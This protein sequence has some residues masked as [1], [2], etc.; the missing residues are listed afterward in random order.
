MYKNWLINI[1]LVIASLTIFVGGME[2][3]LRVTGLQS[4]TPKPPPIY[5]RNTNPHINYELVPNTKQEAYYATVTTNS[6]GFRGTEIEKDKPLVAVLGDSI[7]FGYGVEDDETLPAQ[8]QKLMPN[9]H[10]LNTA[11]PGYDLEQETATYITKVKDLDPAAVMLVFF[12]NDLYAGGPAILDDE[13]ILRPNGWTPDKD[14]CTS[15]SLGNLWFV[16][17]GCWLSKHSAV[18]IKFR[19][20]VDLVS[21]KHRLKKERKAATTNPNN[22]YVQTSMLEEYEAQLDM[23]NKEISPSVPRIFI[24]APEHRVHPGITPQL[25]RIA[26]ERGFYVIDLEDL[27]GTSAKTLYWDTVHPHPSTLEKA[28]TY[29]ADILK[30]RKV[31]ESL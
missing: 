12:Y 24:I 3:F 4:T 25:H 19:K 10:F 13:G 29:I 16:P 26:K 6:L 8:L 20:V 11:V 14:V 22:D 5:Q 30:E 1:G 17:G 7:T 18:F 2:L 23:L 15:N 27:F 21:S 31:L 9:Y 28:A